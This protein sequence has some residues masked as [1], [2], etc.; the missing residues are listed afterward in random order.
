MADDDTFTRLLETMRRAAATLRDA[1]IDFALAGGIAIYARG[2][3][4]TEH[5]VDLLLREEDAERALRVLEENG[6]RSER[7]PEGWLYKAFDRDEMVDLIFAPN[8]RPEVVD[9]LL[10]RA[11]LL[12][13]FAIT[14]K[15]M[16]VTDVL[17]SKLLTL[18]E[19]ELSYDG[20]LEIARACREQIEWER[21]RERA[22]TNPYTK[23]FF[24]LID[25]LDLP[26]QP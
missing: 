11:E 21:L 7:P 17:E 25:E 15:V 6:F 14:V 16:T 5:D 4:A 13:V 22:A 8:G 24:T 23:A 19:H 1:G 12:E 3:P 10:R 2:G 26:T 18:K 20:L 9:D